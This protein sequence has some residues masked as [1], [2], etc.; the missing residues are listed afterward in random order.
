MLKQ[1][2]SANLKKQIKKY[3]N[4]KTKLKMAFKLRHIDEKLNWINKVSIFLHKLQKESKNYMVFIKVTK[5]ACILDNIE[6][7]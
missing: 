1:E 5:F 6:K 7:F 2:N 3:F 4:D